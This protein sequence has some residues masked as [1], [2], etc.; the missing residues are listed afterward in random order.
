ML[1]TTND[2][3]QMT[4]NDKHYLKATVTMP[5]APFPEPELQ[6]ACQPDQRRFL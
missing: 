2:V 1:F 3:K 6:T 5:Y 4:I